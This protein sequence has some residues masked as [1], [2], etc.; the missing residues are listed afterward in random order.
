MCASCGFPAAAG[1]WTEAG[2]RTAPDRWRTR[3]RRTQ[4][5]RSVL[6]AYGLT[7]HEDTQVLGIQVSTL[8]GRHEIVRD[9]SEVWAAAE[10]LAGTAIDP[11]DPRF[12]RPI[13]GA[14]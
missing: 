1:H 6:K 11:L 13:R 9:L 2:A 14:A 5:L 8:S 10:R 3:F 7:A 4:V 12:T